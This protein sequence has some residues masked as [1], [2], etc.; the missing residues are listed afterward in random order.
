LIAERE[1]ASPFQGTDDEAVDRLDGLLRESIGQQMIAD[2]PLGA[3]LSGGIDSSTVVAL[4]QAQRSQPIKTFS[5]GFTDERFNE[6]PQAKAVADHLRTD[7]TEFHV[8]PEELLGLI[9]QLPT[10]YD[11][12]FADSSQIPT[13][14]LCGLT[15]QKVTVSLSGDG[16][17]E[18]FGGYDHY[19]KTEQL[20]NLFRIVPQALRGG[21][22]RPLRSVS[23][24][25]IAKADSPAWLRRIGN[26]LLDYT[27]VLPATSAVSLSQVL[28][29]PCRDAQDF[30]REPFESLTCYGSNLSVS[31]PASVL[32]Q[33][34][35]L[36]AISYLPDD[37]LVKVD[38]A[39]MAVSLETRI[40]FLDHRVV[41]FAWTLPRSLLLRN[42]QGKWLLRQVLKRYVPQ[43]LT[44]RPKKGFAV[45]LSDWLRGPLRG[46]AEGLLEESRIQD[47]GYF[48]S[49]VVRRVWHEHLAQR[50]DWGTLLWN[51]LMFQAWL[52][53][54]GAAVETVAGEVSTRLEAT[55]RIG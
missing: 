42:G 20:W 24:Q 31:A 41:E 22:A 52:E 43:S 5:I 48:Q 54:Q 29:Y 53:N 13:I 11:E 33:I 40:P 46:W 8:R 27:N 55:A 47:Q 51:V 30:L 44:D 16:G 14:L 39:A 19:P 32:Q 15:R 17:D 10:I 37:I 12:P 25:S 26:R 49:K 4:M 23:I 45:P 3:F 35:F 50:R 1:M 7:H 36:D 21:L 38:R 2:V 18:L 28:A 34:M 9:H 6:A